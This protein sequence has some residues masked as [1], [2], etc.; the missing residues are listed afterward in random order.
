[1]KVISFPTTARA[2]REHVRRVARAAMP[3]LDAAAQVGDAALIERI[4]E[5]L[6]A[7]ARGDDALRVLEGVQ[8][9]E[10]RVIPLRGSR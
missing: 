3:R 9:R 5:G 6:G 4:F 7:L 10:A 8:F 1:M 2:R